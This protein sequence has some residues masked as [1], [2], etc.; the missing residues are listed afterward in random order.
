MRRLVIEK[1]NFKATV[2]LLNSTDATPP[3]RLTFAHLSCALFINELFLVNPEAM[4]AV[5]GLHC[6]NPQRF[7]LKCSICKVLGGACVQCSEKKCTTPMHMQCA[8]E[9]GSQIEI[10]QSTSGEAGQYLIFCDKHRTIPRKSTVLTAV[11]GQVAG[12]V[13]A[14]PQCQ[15]CCYGIEPEPIEGLDNDMLQCTGCALQVHRWCWGA[16]ADKPATRTSPAGGADA[17][18][19]SS[20]A[21]GYGAA[22]AN[23]AGSS[24]GSA[25]ALNGASPFLCR[26]CEVAAA[27]RAAG[28]PVEEAACALCLNV[29][30]ALK[31]SVDGRWVCLPCSY[32]TPEL[33]FKDPRALEPIDGLIEAYKARHKKACSL[34]D[35]TSGV[36]LECTNVKCATA[37]HLS[38]AYASGWQLSKNPRKQDQVKRPFISFCGEHSR[39]ASA[40]AASPASNPAYATAT[41]TSFELPDID[42]RDDAALIDLTGS[43][44][45]N[46]PSSGSKRR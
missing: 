36:P 27:R 30:G 16:P 24:P 43:S 9:R 35:R 41:F 37:Y 7:K 18:D 19:I 13:A 21:N 32:F 11:E 31:P 6:V 46:G 5:S 26:V 3:A 38:C 44:S 4:G 33:F 25:P 17:M 15:V 8:L 20:S 28:A 2:A 12:A 45:S 40:L 29:K 34:C 39:A 14:L 23:G 42:A 1:K 22:I 10:K